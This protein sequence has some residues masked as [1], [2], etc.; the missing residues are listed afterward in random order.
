MVRRSPCWAEVTYLKSATTGTRNLLLLYVFALLERQYG[1]ALEICD[2]ALENGGE[3]IFKDCKK[4][5]LAL[6]QKE[7]LK[8]PVV[9]IK[10][11]FNKLFA[12]INA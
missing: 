12:R 10:K 5:A 9:M 7:K 1:L 11:Q 2:A 6:L 4:A 8:I 3:P